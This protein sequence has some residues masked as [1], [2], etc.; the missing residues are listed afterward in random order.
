MERQDI[1][2]SVCMKC[3]ADMVLQSFTSCFSD[4]RWRADYD[5]IKK[6]NKKMFSLKLIIKAENS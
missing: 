2:M 1:A 3:F 4:E 6:A 5:S